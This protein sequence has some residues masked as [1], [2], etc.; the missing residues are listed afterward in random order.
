MAIVPVRTINA[1]QSLSTLLKELAAEAFCQIDIVSPAD[2]ITT[3]CR[4][5]DLPLQII[6][7]YIFKRHIL[8]LML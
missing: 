8:P 5:S 7:V 4:A 1:K 6:S 3:F 2:F